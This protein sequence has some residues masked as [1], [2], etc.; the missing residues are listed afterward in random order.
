MKLPGQGA[1]TSELLQ[2]LTQEPLVAVHLATAL[3]SLLLGA[4]V[5]ARQKG[6]PQHRALGWTWVVLMALCPYRI[7]V[8][9]WS[10]QVPREYM[11][12][13]PPTPTTGSGVMPDRLSGT[14]ISDRPRK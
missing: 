13:L 8:P 1:S 7:G 5:L 14:A 12:M 11:S 2:T 9:F 6:T 3:L 10:A 4:V